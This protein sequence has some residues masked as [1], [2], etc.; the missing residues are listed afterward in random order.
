M[1]TRYAE[2]YHLKVAPG[3]DLAT[4][5]AF[6][7]IEVLIMEKQDQDILELLKA[8]LNFLEK[9]GYGRS[10]HTPWQPTSVFQDSLSC[11]NY[12]D[13]ERTYPC[14]ACLLASFVPPESRAESVPCHH[15][16]LNQSGETVE[17]LERRGDQQELEEAMK[18]WLR[19][20]IAQLEGGRDRQPVA[21][22][23]Q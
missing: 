2:P 8:E 15:I 12:A 19:A 16:P 6:K 7:T 21:L 9:G 10:V 1:N 5:A 13:P 20:R 22:L 23:A 18:T 17:T 11:L 4:G 14:E 3:A